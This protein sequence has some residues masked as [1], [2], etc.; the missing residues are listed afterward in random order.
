MPRISLDVTIEE[1]REII[2]QLPPHE[3]AALT[4]AIEERAETTNMMK[5]AETG[6]DEWNEAGEEIY[7]ASSATQQ[8]N[9]LLSLFAAHPW[10]PG[11]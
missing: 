6:F 7:D 5:L 10:Q 4:Q 11:H 8:F 2:F 3:L 1:I 9:Q